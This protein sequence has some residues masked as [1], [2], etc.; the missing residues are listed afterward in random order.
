MDHPDPMGAMDTHRSE[1]SRV[2]ADGL[3]T[4]SHPEWDAAYEA[5]R[6]E[7][8]PEARRAAHRGLLEVS[9]EEPGWILLRKPHELRAMR[10]G[11]SFEIPVAQ[12]PYVLPFRAGEV[13][14]AEGHRGPR[15]PAGACRAS[16]PSASRGRPSPC[17]RCSSW[18]S[19][20]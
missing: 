8:D 20:S 15:G 17:S 5:A 2:V 7:T 16:W 10:E 4:P 6:C 12:R 1:R 11:L 14:V 18:R 3:R 19:L 9:E 13:S